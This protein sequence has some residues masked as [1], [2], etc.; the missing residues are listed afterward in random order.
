MGWCG[1]TN[2]A[3]FTQGFILRKREY[4]L[5]KDVLEGCGLHS[6]KDYID[7]RRSTIEMYMVNHPI[8][9]QGMKGGGTK[10]RINVVLVVVGTE[11][12]PACITA[13]LGAMSDGLLLDQHS[14]R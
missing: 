7:T 4:H 9:I 10:E 13:Y 1:N 12:W 5:T 14:W 3:R 6:V 8:D 2:L 11:A